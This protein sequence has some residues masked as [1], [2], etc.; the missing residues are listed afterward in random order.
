MRIMN[1]KHMWMLIAGLV[2]IQFACK[3][4][5]GSTIIG[6]WQEAKIRI[7]TKDASGVLLNDT[8]YSGATFTSLDYVQFLS[9]ATC[10]NSETYEYFP[11]GEGF[12]KKPEHYVSGGTLNYSTVEPGL[13]ILTAGGTLVNPGGFVTTDTARVIGPNNLLIRFTSYGHSTSTG[14]TTYDSYYS[15]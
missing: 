1:N 3:K 8:T 10:I 6:K 15:R 13:Y 12:P 2:S 5:S 7:Y 4:E 14:S 11:A 9:N